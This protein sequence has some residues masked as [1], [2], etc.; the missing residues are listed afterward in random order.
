MSS[1]SLLKPLNTDPTKDKV[2][3]TSFNGST[4]VHV[5]HCQFEFCK[6]FMGSKFPGHFLHL[7][8]DRYVPN[9]DGSLHLQRNTTKII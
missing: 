1:N 5:S 6:G 8:D 7:T 9:S 3:Y 4:E 2:L